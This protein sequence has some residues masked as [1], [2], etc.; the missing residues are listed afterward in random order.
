[1]NNNDLRNSEDVVKVIYRVIDEVNTL[2][3]GKMKLEKS[4]NTVIFGENGKLDSLGMVN[5]IVNLEDKIK[6]EF[7]FE[8][9]LS[10]G[11]VIS[12]ENSPLRSIQALAD[13]ICSFKEKT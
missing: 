1:M 10:D 9:F 12:Q 4:L 7:G 3:S 13:Y 11:K 5:F 8:I 6:E 2:L